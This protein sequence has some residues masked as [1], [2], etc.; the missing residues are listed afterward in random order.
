MDFHC[1]DRGLGNSEQKYAPEVVVRIMRRQPIIVVQEGSFLFFLQLQVNFN[2]Y[3][4]YL[5]TWDI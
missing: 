1:Q 5:I 4:R 3:V 2:R